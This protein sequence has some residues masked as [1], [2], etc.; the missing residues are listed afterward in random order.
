MVS[1]WKKVSEESWEYVEDC[2][3]ES[4]LYPRLEQLRLDGSEYRA[5]KRDG[6]FATV[7]GV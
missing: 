2:I 6:G 7:L 5:E 4:A 1:I 3:E